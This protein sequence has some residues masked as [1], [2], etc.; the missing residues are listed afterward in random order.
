M[1]VM[2]HIVFLSHISEG[3]ISA[4]H[5][6]PN[7]NLNSSQPLTPI[8]IFR[9]ADRDDLDILLLFADQKTLHNLWMRVGYQLFKI[10]KIS[11]TIL[12][13]FAPPRQ[14]SSTGAG[15]LNLILAQL[16]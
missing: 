7:R 6:S 9:N 13:T 4:A 16:Q 1:D 10:L 8:T 5:V 12:F 11:D 15:D 2:N 3:I 14:A